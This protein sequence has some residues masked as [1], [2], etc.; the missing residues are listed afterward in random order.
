MSKSRQNDGF[1]REIET[2]GIL[3]YIEQKT[4]IQNQGHFFFEF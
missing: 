3:P 2:L 4:V 1:K